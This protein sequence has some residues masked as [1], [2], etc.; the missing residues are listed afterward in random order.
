MQLARETGRFVAEGC[1]RMRKD[2]TRFWAHVLITPMFDHTGKQIGYA[3]VTR[4][5][6]QQKADAERIA[7]VTRKLDLALENMSQGLCLFDPEGIVILTNR[8]MEEVFQGAG[9]ALAPG[10]NFLT[11]CRTMAGAHEKKPRRR[12]RWRA[13]PAAM[14]SLRRAS[15]MAAASNT[16]RR[17]TSGTARSCA[18]TSTGAAWRRCPMDAP[19]RCRTAPW[20]TAPG[21]PPAR[22]SPSSAASKPR[23]IIWR[24][25]T[26]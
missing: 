19:L 21:S 17:S 26:A 10:A 15:R 25:T 20:P 24:A 8:R 7:E 5:M 23:S 6:T 18:A 12:A 22:M 4:D 1:W 11:L 13:S 9:K 16:R 3:K 14:R 2:G